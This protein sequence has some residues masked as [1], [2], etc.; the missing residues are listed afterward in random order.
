MKLPGAQTF[1]LGGGGGYS[2]TTGQGGGTFTSGAHPGVT[3]SYRPGIDMYVGT[4]ANGDRLFYLF[5]ESPNRYRCWRVPSGQDFE[6]G[7]LVEDSTW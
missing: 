3:F 4:L 7:T 2:I 6:N 5:D 1:T